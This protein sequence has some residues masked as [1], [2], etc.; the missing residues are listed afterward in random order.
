[1]K[2][3]QKVKGFI[4]KIAVERMHRLIELAEQNWVSHP[5]RSR[6]YISLIKKISSRNKAGIPKEIKQKFCKKCNSF[7]NSKNTQI[8]IKEGKKTTKC[9]ECKNVWIG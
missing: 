4:E 5:E 8:R 7:L 3:K 2:S 9:L 6:D 1:M